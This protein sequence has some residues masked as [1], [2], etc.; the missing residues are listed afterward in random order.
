MLFSIN[1]MLAYDKFHAVRC[2]R[3]VVNILPGCIDIKKVLSFDQK[4]I[5]DLCAKIHHLSIRTTL[6]PNLEIDSRVDL[7]S[8]HNL[9][10]WVTHTYTV[11]II[12]HVSLLNSPP[13]VKP[14]WLLQLQGALVILFVI[15]RNDNTVHSIMHI[16]TLDPCHFIKKILFLSSR[17]LCE[18]PSVRKMLPARVPGRTCEC[19]QSRKVL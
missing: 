10:R 9:C 8:R 2:N 19:C 17:A 16:G 11:I 15:T 7:S 6:Q 13:N 1:M 14:D 5:R 12:A 4:R 18:A 3:Q